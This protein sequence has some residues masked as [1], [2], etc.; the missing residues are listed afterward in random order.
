MDEKDHRENKDYSLD[1]SIHCAKVSPYF[2]S[3]HLVHC[4]T[5][6]L[7]LGVCVSVSPVIACIPMHFISQT[8]LF[9]FNEL[10]YDDN[11]VCL[12]TVFCNCGNIQSTMLTHFQH[13]PNQP[14]NNQ[15][16]KMNTRKSY[17]VFPIERIPR[18]RIG[19]SS[20]VLVSLNLRK[21]RL[22]TTLEYYIPHGLEK[23]N[24]ENKNNKKNNT[25]TVARV[26][27]L[28][29]HMSSE[30]CNREGSDYESSDD[31]KKIIANRRSEEVDQMRLYSHL[32][33][34][35]ETSFLYERRVKDE[36]EEI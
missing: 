22:S 14:T 25:T 10:H 12:V 3:R 27:L 17:P 11:D 5:S 36:V 28:A 35:A 31:N 32:D 26:D 24:M 15:T 29:S 7:D 19:A 4:S 34:Q 16:N 1:S 18:F 23:T 9:D 21:G 8:S 33:N 30:F 20:P 6:F 2:D 13:S